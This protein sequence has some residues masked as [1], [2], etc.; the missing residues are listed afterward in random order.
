MTID[1][2][3]PDT[4]AALTLVFGTDKAADKARMAKVRKALRH[5]HGEECPKCECSDGIED[6]G[7]DGYERSYLCPKCHHQWDA[8]LYSEV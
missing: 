8:E 6:N 7:C 1:F 4:F 2:L 5:Y 3:S